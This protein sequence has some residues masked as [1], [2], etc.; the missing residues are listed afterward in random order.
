MLAVWF[1]SL[2]A[3]DL[4]RTRDGS[5]PADDGLSGGRVACGAGELQRVNDGFDGAGELQRVNDELAEL[6]KEELADELK[7]EMR[8]ICGAWHLLV[9]SLVSRLAGPPGGVSPP[10][11][12]LSC[13]S[14]VA[15]L[16]HRLL[17]PAMLGGL[18]DD[19]S[20]SSSEPSPRSEFKDRA[21]LLAGGVP[22]GQAATRPLARRCARILRVER[23]RIRPRAHKGSIMRRHL[24]AHTL[25]S[26]AAAGQYS[27][28][29]RVP[30]RPCR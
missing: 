24:S 18:D 9:L 5:R 2:S 28:P 1:W 11:R 16:P 30:Q 13:I 17:R 22:I 6:L 7:Q 19:P 20:P 29:R 10:A 3:C 25:G 14:S 26:G 27:W 23:A 15:P 4:C 21:L 8:I 12:L